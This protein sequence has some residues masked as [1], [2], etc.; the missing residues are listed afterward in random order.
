MKKEKKG[1]RRRK[2]VVIQKAWCLELLNKYLALRPACIIGVGLEGKTGD[3]QGTD[4]C[5]QDQ[6]LFTLE[7]HTFLVSLVPHPQHRLYVSCLHS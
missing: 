3:F 2:E 5:K 1:E 4:P 7:V 6:T